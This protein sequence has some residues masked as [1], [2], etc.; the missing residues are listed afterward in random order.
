MLPTL[1]NEGIAIHDIVR[2]LTNMTFK[3]EKLEETTL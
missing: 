3:L 2:V 1:T